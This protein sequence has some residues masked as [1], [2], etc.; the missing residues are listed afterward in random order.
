MNKDSWEVKKLGDIATYINGYSFK[1]SDWEDDGLPII[2]I[3]NLNSSEAPYNYTTKR[4]DKKY[5]VNFGEILISWSASLGVYEWKGTSALLNQHIFKVQFDKIEI[6][7]FFFKYQVDRQIEEML[8]HIH[9]ATMKHITKKNFDNI[10]F[11]VPPP[12]IQE[13]IVKELDALSDIITKK[14]EQ[15]AELDKLAQATFYDM[16]GDPVEN[17]KQWESKKLDEVCTKITDGTHTSPK[18]LEKGIPFLFV[19]N[20][21]NNELNFNTQKYISNEEYERLTKTTKIEQW[22][23]LYTSV[24]TFGNPAIIKTNEK[25][26]FQRHIAHLKPKHKIINIIFFHAVMKI[27][28]VKHQA[29]RLAI[30]VAQKTLNL[31]AIKKIVIP[32]PPISLQ[33]Q[34]AEKIEAIEKQKALINQS[35]TDTQ[36]LFDYTMDKYFN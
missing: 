4:I 31:S 35:I 16:F 15:L 8:Q 10:R 5:V 34:F 28:Y 22:D 21:Q 27:D 24:G 9:G 6:N 12:P 17:E 7:K 13:Q 29:N 1:P 3:Q 20:I 14:K 18:F 32:I 33:T 23:L 36:L 19:S 25:F 2:R 11:L 30:G 26:C